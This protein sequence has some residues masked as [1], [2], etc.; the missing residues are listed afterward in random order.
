MK[1]VCGTSV[2]HSA[3]HNRWENNTIAT[4]VINGNYALW[5]YNCWPL[6]NV[7]LDDGNPDYQVCIQFNPLSS[8]Q[9]GTDQASSELSIES[10]D[11][12]LE[13]QLTSMSLE[14]A[15]LTSESEIDAMISQYISFISGN[16]DNHAI[17]SLS[18]VNK[19]WADMH[20]L[21]DKYYRLVNLDSE[22]FGFNQSIA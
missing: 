17:L 15:E 9:I 7:I 4:P 16:I 19:A 3:E 20:D 12:N 14:F 13:A 10:T 5:V 18:V 21:V 22:N 1:V 6:T 2:T 8:N 11:N